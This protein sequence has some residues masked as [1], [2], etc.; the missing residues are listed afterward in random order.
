MKKIAYLIFAALL[1]GASSS[2]AA[3][4]LKWNAT[5]NQTKYIYSITG[6][7]SIDWG[8]G[9][10]DS[11][12]SHTYTT[13]GNYTVEVSGAVTEFDLR[14]DG[15]NGE[16][17]V[18]DLSFTE[19]D[20][21][22]TTLNIWANSSL[23]N[24]NLQNAVALTRLD[25]TLLPIIKLDLTKN[26][27][28]QS[29]D[30]KRCA[31]ISDLALPETFPNLT[32]VDANNSALPACQLNALFKSLSTNGG[33]I[34]SVGCT[35]DA[36]SDPTIATNKG[37]TFGNGGAG[38]GSAVCETPLSAVSNVSSSKKSED[39]VVLFTGSESATSYSV[40]VLKEGATDCDAVFYN[41]TS[42]SVNVPSSVVDLE[43]TS[44]YVYSIKGTQYV[45]AGPF[46]FS[47]NSTDNVE[48]KNYA[49]RV[50]VDKHIV[51][52]SGLSKGDKITLYRVSGDVVASK[53]ALEEEMR[54]EVSS[55]V[56]LVK[57]GSETEK[58]VVK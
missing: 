19:T 37:W 40:K 54:F 29:L 1:L 33:T 42:E 55:G 16:S 34:Y 43:T 28:L 35:G 20:K 10:T 51:T 14:G 53:V 56:Y 27:A 6:T 41:S 30:F 45:E 23:V 48:V 32:V 58:V 21:T 47:D 36:T 26:T 3:I 52:V 9:T 39:Y 44:F 25:I 2:F 24:L 13:A 50:Y 49:W 12:L 4:Q 7:Y 31:S 57:H 22:L 8:D 17:G 11:N 15:S 46:K 18:T 5:A 38:D